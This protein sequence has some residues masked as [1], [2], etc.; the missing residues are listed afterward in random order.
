L[1]AILNNIKSALFISALFLVSLQSFSQDNVLELLPGAET[2]EYDE[3]TGVHRLLG[4]VNF[5]YQGNVMYC[6]SAH[7]FER[8]KSV[9]AYSRVHINK[10]D[11]LNLYCDSLYYDGATRKA[12]L[13]GNVRARD[14]EFKLTTDTLDYDT[15]SGQAHYHYGGRVESIV[16][17]EVLTS[18]VGYFHPDSKNFF[19]SK[20]VEYKGKDLSMQTD[21]LQYVYSQKRLYFF[22]PTDIVSKDS[23][24]YC[25]SGWY[26]TSTEEG[27]LHQNA[28]ISK[29]KDYIAG[30]TLLYNPI[31]G[32]SIGI[33]NVYYKDSTQNLEFNGDYA[34][35]SDTLDFSFLT[36]HA[37]ATKY[38]K[39][40]TMY[41]HADTL[42]MEKV[43]SI[44]IMKAYN[45]AQ[46]YSTKVQCV[47]DSITFNS[48]EEKI[49]LYKKPIVWAKKA[50]L[51]GVF[52]EIHV[53]DS[54]IHQVSIQN[55][56][57]ILMEV[58]PGEYYNQ[59][60]GENILAYFD[61]NDLTQALVNG[62]AITVFFPED[63]EKTD[64]TFTKKRM[65]MNRVY[66]SDLR[67]DIDSNEISGITYLEEPDGVFYPMDQLN[68]DEQFIKGF[69]W[70]N[71]LRPQSKEGILEE[72]D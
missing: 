66:S 26:N 28:W 24:M 33:G 36:G 16:T 55:K 63:E 29:E 72:E 21:T 2:L 4:N 27:S 43:D 25:E 53:S 68:K 1:I 35:S 46:I 50:E 8:E 23:K 38:L 57:S 45:N 67:I 59:I 18:K 9:R 42:Y 49:S 13:W 44:D 54:L 41:V 39:D 5:I 7:Y 11:T 17:Q 60:A 20:N 37:V 47:A 48:S 56:S 51:K 62:N 31:E 6:D 32:Y 65:G 64:S 10:N 71:H 19:F 30:D 69:D 34:Y 61:D 52:I 58:E 15:N 22:G 3:I 12:K 40:D 70:M 14:N